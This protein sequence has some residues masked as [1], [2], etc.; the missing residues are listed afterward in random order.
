MEKI[1]KIKNMTKT[2][3]KISMKYLLEGL[4]LGPVNVINELSS[5][6]TAPF[7]SQKP[8]HLAE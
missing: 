1:N 3:E 5:F 4:F 6:D 2:G 7:P 8:Q